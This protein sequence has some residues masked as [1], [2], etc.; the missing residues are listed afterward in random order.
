MDTPK[1][2]VGCGMGIARSS[3]ICAKTIFDK[4]SSVGKLALNIGT[5][6][7]SLG[8]SAAAIQTKNAAEAAMV[9][10]SLKKDF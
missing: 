5:A 10:P 6:I 2:W 3:S 9:L 1:N 7:V 4:I 8:G